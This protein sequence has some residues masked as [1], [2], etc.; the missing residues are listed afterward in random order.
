MKAGYEIGRRQ[1]V[2]YRDWQ[3]E[4]IAEPEKDIFIKVRFKAADPD[5][6]NEQSWSGRK[7]VVSIHSTESEIVTT[8]LKA[9]LT[10]EEHEAREQ[11][12][13]CGKPIFN[14]HLDVR[15][16]RE[17]ASKLDVREGIF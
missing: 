7:W 6:G 16:M 5:T 1:R 3:F 9:V 12:K 11:F 4:V 15:W 13:F 8:C 17:N 14:P 10:A 2:P